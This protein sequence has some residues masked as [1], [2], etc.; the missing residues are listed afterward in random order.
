MI[1]PF[2]WLKE[3]L[4]EHQEWH[5]LVIGWGD[6][7][8]FRNTDWRGINKIYGKEEKMRRELHYYKA[9]L[10]F[11]V[12]SLIGFITAMACIFKGC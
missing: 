1:P 7:F 2:K 6:G 3:F 11:G 9:G 5:A 4:N 12:L 8:S 10:G